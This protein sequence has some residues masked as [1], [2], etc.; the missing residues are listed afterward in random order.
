MEYFKAAFVMVFGIVYVA[1]IMRCLITWSE[2]QGG[3]S[4]RWDIFR[5]VWGYGHLALLLLG[6]LAVIFLSLVKSFS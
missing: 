4:S 1:S 6:M 3:F 5:F 2:D